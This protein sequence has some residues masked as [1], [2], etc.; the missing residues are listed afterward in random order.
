MRYD[1]TKFVRSAIADVITTLFIA[2]GLVIVVVFVFLQNRRA[3]LFRFDGAGRDHRHVRVV[4]ASGLLDQH[5][6]YVRSGAG[7]RHRRNDAIVVVE[8]VQHIG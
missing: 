1:A 3:T 2:V 4:S 8:A 6:E 5:H 7:D